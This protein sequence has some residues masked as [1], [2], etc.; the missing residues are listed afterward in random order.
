MTQRD[1]KPGISGVSVYVP[2]PRVSLERWCEW[3]GSPW[4]KIEAVVGR[5]FRICPP[6]EN[7]Y[8]MAASAVMRL[9][10]AYGVDPQKVGFLA[11][12][13][14][15]STDNAAGAVIVRGMVDQVPMIA[16]RRACSLTEN[17]GEAV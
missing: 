7:A 11:L 12:G 15:S 2:R 5:S 9:I 17:T 8:T 13:T 1:S 4:N 3:T 10:D 16:V 6:E 14:E